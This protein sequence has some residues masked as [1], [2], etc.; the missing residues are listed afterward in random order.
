MT[1]HYTQH[2]AVPAF[3][4]SSLNVFNWFDLL[5]QM[6]SLSESWEYMY[7]HVLYVCTYS[8]YVRSYGGEIG[9]SA[10]VDSLP[11]T[12]EAYIKWVSVYV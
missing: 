2:S 8:T 7:T 9:Y 11:E 10:K 6:D 12:R 1:P 3:I 5:Q 4:L